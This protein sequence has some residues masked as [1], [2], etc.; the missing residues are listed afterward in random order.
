MLEYNQITIGKFIIWNGPL[1]IYEEGLKMTTEK[2]A[3]TLAQSGAYSIVG[4]GDTLATIKE[5]G[6]LDKFGFVSTGGGAMLHF[7]AHGTLPG[8]EA[9]EHSFKRQSG[10]CGVF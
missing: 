5:L 4:D 9:L 8:I 1:G 2:L 3:N 10:F 6:I 7:L